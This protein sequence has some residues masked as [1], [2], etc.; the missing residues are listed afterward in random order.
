M[1]DIEMF[2]DLQ[3]SAQNPESWNGKFGNIPKSPKCSESSVC[4]FSVVKEASVYSL[5]FTFRY[6]PP[7]LLLSLPKNVSEALQKG[8][9]GLWFGLD[10]IPVL[11]H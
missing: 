5:Y 9:D 1:E 3:A 11:Q 2:Q 8:V 7:I 4:G 6:W 10:L